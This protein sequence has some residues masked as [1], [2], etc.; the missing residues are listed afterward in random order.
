MKTRKKKQIKTIHHSFN[1]HLHETLDSNRKWTS[2]E[3]NNGGAEF[4]FRLPVLV[5]TSSSDHLITITFT[6]VR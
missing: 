6:P 5:G 3:T 1:M 4:D 2:R